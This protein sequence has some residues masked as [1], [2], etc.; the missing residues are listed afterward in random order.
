MNVRMSGPEDQLDGTVIAE[1]RLSVQIT[2][3]EAQDIV[4]RMAAPQREAEGYYRCF[5]ELIAP[6]YRK[7]RYAAGV[8][9]FQAIHLATRMIGVTLSCLA[10][11]NGYHFTFDDSDNIGFPDFPV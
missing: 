8:D 2:G 1:R 11:E 10:R 7:V 5:W 3:T 9:G 6:G 4:V